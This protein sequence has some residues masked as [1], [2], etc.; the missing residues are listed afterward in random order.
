[1]GIPEALIL[2]GAE[3]GL[4][5]DLRRAFA[6]TTPLWYYILREAEV[7]NEGEWLGPVGG[8][9]VAEVL[10]GLLFGDRFSYPRAAPAWT[11]TP[12]R[13][14]ARCDDSSRQVVFGMPEMLRFSHS[15]PSDPTRADKTEAG[16]RDRCL[17]AS[18][19]R[20]VAP[21]KEKSTVADGTYEPLQLKIPV[22]G[23]NLV[24]L[25]LPL[26]PPELDTPNVF[27]ERFVVN[28]ARSVKMF[29]RI[30]S[31]LFYVET[32]PGNGGCVRLNL[33]SGGH[34]KGKETVHTI[35]FKGKSAQTD[36]PRDTDIDLVEGDGV[37]LINEKFG[38]TCPDFEGARI[39]MAGIAPNAN[40]GGS[41][42]P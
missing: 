40:C 41:P 6:E 13:F 4:R 32:V 30:G 26:T 23:T 18:R 27:L 7:L 36:P 21:A 38:F 9:I 3:L 37:L 20:D 28:N 14:G 24:G 33:G 17:A 39:L 15:L 42:C 31:Y 8:R 35:Y 16:A 19:D 2:G 5:G 1:M 34:F 11:P 29:D 25:I 22:D 12:D 10:I